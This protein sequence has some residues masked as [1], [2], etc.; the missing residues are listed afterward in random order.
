MRKQFAVFGLGSFGKSVALTLESFGCDVIVVDN[1][2]EKVQEISDSV[3][4]A[5]RADASD[6]DAMKEL[7]GR[8]LDA[9][10]VAISEDMEAGIMATIISKEMGIPYVLAKAKNDLQG[11]ILKKVGAD[12]VV[13]PERDMGCRV[14]KN[15]VSAAFTDWIELSPEY[16][17]TEKLIPKQ[18]VGKSLVELKI[19]EKYGMNVVGIM[20]D[21]HVDVT[22][23][24]RNPLPEDCILIIIGANSVLEKFEENRI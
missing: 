20:K 14:A 4:Y 5:I 8:N 16:S 6:P 1:S 9:A 23:N 11:T 12:E 13:F 15:L 17:L 10:I 19:R 22:F 24:P 3:A 18:W 2:Y 21:G 7:G